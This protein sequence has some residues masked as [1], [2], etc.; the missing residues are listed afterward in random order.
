MLRSLGLIGLLA[1]AA[2][3]AATETAASSEQDMSPTD[4]LFVGA[5]NPYPADLSLR[6]RLPTLKASQAARR[7]Q[8][9]EIAK[10]VLEPITVDNGTQTGKRT[11]PRFQT[12]YAKEEVTALFH[13]ILE[14]QTPADRAAHR[15]PTD[16]EVQ[17]SF[18]W[19]AARATGTA[20]GSEQKIASR[21]Q[22]LDTNGDQ[23]LG[24]PERVLMSPE[25]VAHLFK[26]YDPIIDCIQAFPG[27][28]D[29]PPSDTNFAA[30]VGTE[31]PEG[32]VIVKTVWTPETIALGAYDTSADGL[33]QALTAGEWPAP[34][35]TATPTADQ[36]YT[37]TVMPTGIRSRLAAMHIMSKELR[38][39]AWVSLFWSDQPNVDFGADRP[40]DLGGS[41]AS[42]F[43]NYKM[44]TTVAY[45]EEDDGSSLAGADP[46]LA[47]AIGATR[48]FGQRTWCSNPYLEAGHSNAKTNCIG[49]HQH[50]GTDLSTETIIQGDTPFPDGSRAQSRQNF[51]ADYTFITSTGLGLN[52]LFQAQVNS[53]KPPAP[54]DGAST[55]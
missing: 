7:K 26:N 3:A 32:A 30:C 25:A 48:A 8:A 37:M 29:A 4:R 1:V 39:W 44:C 19:I 5:A 27:P 51:P 49:C 20:Q 10:R 14:G 34:A 6:D 23:S 28:N 35:R 46:T 21:R 13:H 50:A 24:G 38:D 41:L 2:C 36:I 55:H 54:P 40:A 53:F 15:P 17:E 12:W 11:L 16:A 18:A 43:A 33:T 45:D 42:T 22:D 9:W 47:A 31:F 52:Y